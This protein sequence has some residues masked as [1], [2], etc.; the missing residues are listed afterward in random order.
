MIFVLLMVMVIVVTLHLVR[1]VV[2]ASVG[3]SWLKSVFYVNV[4]FLSNFQVNQITISAN[5]AV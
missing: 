5:T 3:V 4:F 1:W 2:V